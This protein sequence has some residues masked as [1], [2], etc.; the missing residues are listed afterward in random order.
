MA[1]STAASRLSPPRPR[2]ASPP[3]TP[4]RR[5]RFSPL[6][7]AKM[8]AVLS[9][10][11]HV[12][13]H[14]RKAETGGEDAF[15]VDSD[16]GGV[17]A[18]ADG[19]SGWAE[20]NVNPA[21]FSRELMANSSAFLKD[22]EVRHD[23][24]ILLMKAHAATSSVGSATVIIAMLEKNGTLK[25]ASVGDCGLKIIRK[26]QVMFSTCP[27][28]HYFDCPYQ[29]SSEAV[30]QTYQDALVCTVNLVEGDMIVSGS[31]G[32]FDNIFDQ[33]ILDVIAES[34]G[35]DE[36]AK[37]LAE[38]ARKHS[39]DVNFDS[40]YSMEARS[41][42]FDVPWWKKLLGAKLIGGKMDD[43][44]VI[45]AQVKTVVIPDDEGSGVEQEQG[46]ELGTGAAV[47]S[48]E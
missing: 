44:T 1:A 34:P 25:I 43:I 16:T 5:S 41:R 23:P 36:A 46:S 19:V 26:G 12:I 37:A 27:Q 15:F 35:V 39:V 32:F 29:I 18:I 33:E 30:S 20:R 14:P 47:V 3:S 38:L 40:P 48:A 9:V 6:R 4:P 17:F 11:A 2:T 10:G 21:L 22:E 45:V 31:D 24:Q 13:P 7:A 28:E 8:E 42:G